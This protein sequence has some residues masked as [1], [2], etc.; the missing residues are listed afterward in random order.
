MTGG[1][2]LN[3][4]W[5][6]GSNGSHRI[7]LLRWWFGE[8][9]SAQ[10]NLFT[11]VPHRVDPQS[12][13]TWQATADDIAT[14]TLGMANG[15]VANIFISAVARHNLGNHVEVVGS[16]GTATLAHDSPKLFVGRAGQELHDETRANPDGSLPGIGDDV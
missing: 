10:G 11:A 9:D 7:D 8:V 2:R 1:Q 4:G 13:T 15:V 16:E 3:G 12:G 6:P 5:T 14:F